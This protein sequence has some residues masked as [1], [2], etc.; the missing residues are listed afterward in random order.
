MKLAVVK[1]QVVSTVKVEGIEGLPLLVVEML[2]AA[3][4]PSGTLGVAADPIGAG[5]GET[6]LVV[7]GSSAR[8]IAAGEGPLDLAIVGIVDLVTLGRQEV[9]R[10]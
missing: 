5:L 6:V 4:Q 3:C 8:R 9:F 7:E 1:G 2:D 10:K